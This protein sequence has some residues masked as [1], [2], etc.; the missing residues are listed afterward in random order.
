[1]TISSEFTITPETENYA[2]AI[3]A[4][5]ENVFGP[6]RF[7]RTAFRVR[8]GNAPDARF[9]FVA[10]KGD[11][12]V[13]S[14]RLTAV[15]IAHAE[16]F[17]LGPLCVARCVQNIGIGRALVQKGLS[18]VQEK[19]Q[20]PV[21]LVGDAPYY[22]P[23]GFERTP[24][25]IVMPGPVDYSRLLIAWPEGCDDCNREDYHGVIKGLSPLAVPHAGEGAEE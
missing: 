12:L 20:L 25:G 13:G 14:V 22:A 1:M 21:L 24:K 23:L 18:M 3:E 2:A 15:R 19:A 8:E 4:L 16:A 7:A 17:L 5:H 6:G 11:K 9:S 10:L